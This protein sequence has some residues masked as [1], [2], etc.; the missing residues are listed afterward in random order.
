[1]TVDAAADVLAGM[2]AVYAAARA[3]GLG[4]DGSFTTQAEHAVDKQGLQ[5]REIGLAIIGAGRI[6]TIFAGLGE[7]IGL[8][9]PQ[10]VAVEKVFVNVNPNSTLLLGQA[11]GAALCALADCGLDVQEYTALQIKKAV[12][13]T[14]NAEKAQVHAM[15][16]RLL[17]GVKIA[18]SDAA[19]ALAVAI[20]H[21]HHLASAR[22]IA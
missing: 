15:V 6:G 17:P 16:G 10:Q 21:A 20:C 19:D 14:G 5:R 11:R 2:P 8:H 13:G 22:R 18:G 7:L 3:R 9:Q 1:M 4:Y 12:V